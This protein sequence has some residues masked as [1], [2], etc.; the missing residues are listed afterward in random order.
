MYR[1]KRSI[2][3]SSARTGVGQASWRFATLDDRNHYRYDWSVTFFADTSR[4]LSDWPNMIRYAD[5]DGISL[6]RYA[7][8]QA[9]KSGLYERIAPGVF[10][11]AGSADDTTAAWAAI[12]TKQPKAT[13]CLLT[14][15]SLHDLTDEIPRRSNVAIP[16][17]MQPVTVRFAPITW[18][19]FNPATFDLGRGDHMLPGGEAIGLYG[20]ERTIIDFFRARH[21]WG[22]DLATSI[23]K[24]W[25]SEH[26]H[27][28]AHL[29]AMAK[30]FPDAY[31]SLLSTMEVLL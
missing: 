31:P 7:L 16:R 15:A 12:A 27:A 11:R 3:K 10:R 17:G 25:L 18:H 6:S 8:E 24:R 19:R 28:P 1:L 13:L 23:L 30:Q 9:V 29:L 5:L 22:A 4:S 2:S 26:G 14:A 20:P 21:T